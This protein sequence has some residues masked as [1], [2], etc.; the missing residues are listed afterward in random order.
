[1]GLKQRSR[2][3]CKMLV[4]LSKAI[5]S[6]E[7]ARGRRLECAG[8]KPLPENA[9]ASMVQIRANLVCH[10][11]LAGWRPFSGQKR[12]ISCSGV[13]NLP[14]TEKNKKLFIRKKGEVA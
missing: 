8:S 5:F 12:Q 14:S 13:E 2:P 1:M 7:L 9:R 4:M 6:G 11:I 10:A 3:P